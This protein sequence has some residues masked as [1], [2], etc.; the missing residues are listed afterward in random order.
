MVFVRAWRRR[1]LNSLSWV[2]KRVS[3]LSRRSSFA[4]RSMITKKMESKVEA[5]T[6]PCL[7]PF[8]MGKLPDSDPLC[9]TWPCWP[10]W[11]WRRV[12]RN[13]GPGFSTLH[14]GWQYQMLFSRLQ[15]LYLD[16]CSVLCIP[17]ISAWARRSCLLLDLTDFLACFLVL[18]LGFSKTRAKIL[19][20]METRVMPRHFEQS[21]I[22]SNI[23]T[24]LTLI[25]FR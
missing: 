5:N 10:S 4:S 25:L 3:L 23:L 9:L 6:H 8:E 20:A 24:L 19:A 12:V 14:G 16:P 13:F 7:G 11:S 15:K 22:Y 1:R 17:L 18:L 2:R 21:D